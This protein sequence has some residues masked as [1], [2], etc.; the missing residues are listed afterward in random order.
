MSKE[1]I[2]VIT[3]EQDRLNYFTDLMQK[4][5][6][7]YSRLFRIYKDAPYLSEEAQKVSDAGRE[8]QFH[9]D[10]VEMLENGYRKQSKGVWEVCSDEY[11]ICASEFVCSNCKESFVSSE[12]TDEEFLGMMKYC[13]NC[14]AKMKGG[15]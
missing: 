11:E 10:V 1:M 13:P 5:Q 12:L 8:A 4:A 14:G 15:E 6:I 7:R 3:Y 9:G 2:E